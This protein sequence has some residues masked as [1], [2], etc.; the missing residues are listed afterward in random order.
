MDAARQ[1]VRWSIPGSLFLLLGVSTIA[2]LQLTWGVPAKSVLGIGKA[3]SA[4]LIIA[5]FASIPIGFVVWIVYYVGYQPVRWHLLSRLLR[6]PIVAL[7]RGG[8]ILAKMSEAGPD[9]LELC[10]QFNGDKWEISAVPLVTPPLRTRWPK[11]AFIAESEPKT[12][13]YHFFNPSDPDFRDPTPLF[14]VGQWS[15][16]RRT[17]S[18][19]LN[20]LHILTLTPAPSTENG[21]SVEARRAS[22]ALTDEYRKFC[23]QNWTLVN[24]IV[25]S[26]SRTDPNGS[27]QKEFTESMDIYHSLGTVRTSATLAGLFTTIYVMG[28]HFVRLEQIRTWIAITVLYSF[29]AV[30]WWL[31]HSNRRD[32]LL[33]LE[34]SM[35]M[36]LYEEVVMRFRISRPDRRR[37]GD[38]RRVADTPRG[39]GVQ[40]PDDGIPNRRVRLVDRRVG[41]HDRRSASAGS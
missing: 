3:S 23:K 13:T 34:S 35:S 8:F 11:E 20:P 41:S 24:S 10:R 28:L 31:A 2:A 26:S 7:D 27:L 15:G 6:Q 5:P 30:F 38:R 14:T 36:L 12:I 37:H 22:K 29:L 39:L 17:V 40:L 18:K 25:T 9:V 1:V 32:S 4:L 21:G 19:L 33:R 16:K